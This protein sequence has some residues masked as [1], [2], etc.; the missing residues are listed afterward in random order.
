MS[1]YIRPRRPGA[2]LFLTITL[3]Q[4]GSTTLV[5]RIESLRR[6]VRA[7]MEARPFRIDAWVILPD[8]MHCVWTLPKGDGDYATRW[9]AIKSRFTRSLRDAGRV[10]FQPTVAKRLGHPVGW[11]P[12]LR[13]SASKVR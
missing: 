11:N 1:R 9:G 4:R 8:H 12:T 6:S 7:T 10:G 5:D 13:K 3:A 2:C